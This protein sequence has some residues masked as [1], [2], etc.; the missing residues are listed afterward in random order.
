MLQTLERMERQVQSSGGRWY[1]ARMLPYR[2][3]EEK[4]VGIV[5]TFIDITDRKRAEE[6]R[7]RLA[8]QVSLDRAMLDASCG[9]CPPASSSR[10]TPPA[11]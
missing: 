6:E 2:T 4:I 1:L 9:T 5:L 7:E 10:N 11:T 3:A 8:A